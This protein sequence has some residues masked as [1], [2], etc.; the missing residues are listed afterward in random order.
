MAIS[1]VNGQVIHFFPLSQKFYCF[2]LL[3]RS[4]QCPSPVLIPSYLPLPA[5]L[6]HLSESPL[7][8]LWSLLEGVKASERES[9]S[10]THIVLF[11]FLL[12]VDNSS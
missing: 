5:A 6:S 11:Y 3:I 8:Q 2:I 10:S 9:S 4:V 12:S 1:P 7:A